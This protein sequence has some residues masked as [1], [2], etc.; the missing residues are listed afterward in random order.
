MRFRSRTINI[1]FNRAYQYRFPNPAT[2][3]ELDLGAMEDHM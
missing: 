2:S 1:G 3:E